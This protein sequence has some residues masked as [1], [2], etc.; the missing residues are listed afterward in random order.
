[1]LQH[2]RLQRVSIAALI[3]VL[4]LSLPSLSL[5]DK[6]KK[7]TNLSG[8]AI[9]WS[10]P[11]NIAAKDLFWGNG[12]EDR[13]PKPPF[14]FVKEDTGAT[15]PKID[16]T[17]AN[18][19]K[20]KVK[21]GKEVHAEVAAS[22]LVWAFGY[23]VDETYFVRSGKIEGATGLKRAKS[24]IGPDG[25]FQLARFE[26]RSKNITRTDINW[27]WGDN[28][29]LGSQE[30]SGLR[31]LMTMLNNWDTRRRS[32]NN[33]V[34][35]IKR[36]DGTVEDWYVVADLGE[37][38]GH[39]ASLVHRTVWDLDAFRK[40]KLID[41]VSGDTLYLAYEG[42]SKSMNKIPL[43]HARWFA[44]MASQLTEA[45]V[46]RAFEAAGATQAEINGFS[47]RIMQKISELEAAVSARP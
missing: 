20:W 33:L 29:F 5:N 45:Q 6:T 36:D 8:K 31:I 2:I 12:S 18:G 3:V 24:F 11:G 19:K 21:F 41:R 42:G 43:E 27:A 4:A 13:A 40:Q 35:E 38:F 10:D 16:V 25:S 37:T 44:R 30:L 32:K 46:R 23:M 9:I 15:Q 17:D 14:Q 22:R 28:P 1:M 39:M 47:W 26:K 7:K 34:E